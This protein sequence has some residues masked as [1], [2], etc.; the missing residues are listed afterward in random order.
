MKNLPASTNIST[1][2]DNHFEQI[3]KYIEKFS[4]SV[5]FRGN[6]ERNVKFNDMLQKVLGF[7]KVKNEINKASKTSKNQVIKPSS[8]K[9]QLPDEV[10][11]KIMSYLTSKD[12][13][14]N[15]A[16]VCKHFKNLSLD[17]QAIKCLDLFGITNAKKYKSVLKVL[18]RSNNLYGLKIGG[19][20]NYYNRLL[21]HSLKLNP[22]MKSL[23][24]LRQFK[25][26]TKLSKYSELSSEV[27]SAF[28]SDLEHLELD[29]VTMTDEL[30]KAISVQKKLKTLKFYPS[31]RQSNQ[32]V[33]IAKNCIELENVTFYSI[34]F[35]NE[36]KD[37]VPA[38]DTFFEERSSTLKHL[39]ITSIYKPGKTFYQEQDRFMKNVSLCQNLERLQIGTY[40][41]VLTNYGLDIITKLTN[42]RKLYLNKLGPAAT[43]INSLLQ[44]SNLPNLEK[45]VVS[46]SNHI[47]EDFFTTLIKRQSFNLKDVYIYNCPNLKIQPSTL[48]SLI[49]KKVSCVALLGVEWPTI[50]EIS[51]GMLQNEIKKNSLYVHVGRT[52]VGI[53]KYIRGQDMLDPLAV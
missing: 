23:T 1:M 25:P 45:I 49:G 14:A 19:S 38:Y 51:W 43:E 40:C 53:S 29:C 30:S 2:S 20:M 42:L 37:N 48:N 47:T 52:W 44:E 5:I 22:N 8:I 21:E 6:A 9:V 15:F 3:L 10:W 12:I 33:T 17:S 11:L 41:S 18:E 31:T 4:E 27:V 28:G 39:E 13:F 36:Y 34:G 46:G 16:L 7:Q 26:N 50:A 24:F 32:L 35:S